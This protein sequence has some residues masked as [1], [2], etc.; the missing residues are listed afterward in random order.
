MPA[1]Q[2]KRLDT[3]LTILSSYFEEFTKKHFHKLERGLDLS[4]EDLKDVMEEILKLNPKPA[5]AFNESNSQ[6]I[7]YII[8][9]FIILHIVT[10]M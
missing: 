3:A 9:D 10:F 7:Q 4:G 6:S 2:K 8:P 5:S 1:E